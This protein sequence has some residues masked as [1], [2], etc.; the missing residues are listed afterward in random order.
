MRSQALGIEMIGPRAGSD[1]RLNRMLF[2]DLAMK[3]PQDL[4]EGSAVRALK[5]ISS[6]R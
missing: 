4:L 3:E 2:P 6:L 1:A 5:R